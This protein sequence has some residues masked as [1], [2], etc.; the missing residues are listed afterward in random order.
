M[1]LHQDHVQYS[2]KYQAD[3]VQNV[4]PLETNSI[5]DFWF[6]LCGGLAL[7]EDSD[8]GRS[9]DKKCRNDYLTYNRKT[10]E[11]LVPILQRSVHQI[12]FIL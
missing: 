4:N 1:V 5:F 12:G 11:I 10:G 3:A 7:E 6:S 8:I 2:F 9:N